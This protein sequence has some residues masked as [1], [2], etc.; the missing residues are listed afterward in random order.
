MTGGNGLTPSLL[1]DG[2]HC[3]RE[4][5]LVFLVVDRNGIIVAD[6]T[7]SQARAQ[8]RTLV[9]EFQKLGGQGEASLTPVTCRD[10]RLVEYE[11][12]GSN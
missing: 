10:G 7:D 12:E 8:L 3:Q 4:T 9:A 11:L 2:Q 1:T 5:T 6:H